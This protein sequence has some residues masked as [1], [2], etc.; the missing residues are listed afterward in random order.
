MVTACLPPI[1]WRLRSSM[2]FLIRTVGHLTPYAPQRRDGH[3]FSQ[4]CCTRT[5]CNYCSI[6]SR[7]S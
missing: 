4:A 3:P 7:F 1:A 5:S 6:S 2:R